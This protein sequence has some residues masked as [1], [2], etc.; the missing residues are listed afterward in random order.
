[1]IDSQFAVVV[2]VDGNGVMQINH[3]V[4]I[5]GQQLVEHLRSAVHVFLE[6]NHYKFC[7]NVSPFRVCQLTG[8]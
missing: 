6:T 1:L 3:P 8:P 2:T 7:H 5:Q 4:V